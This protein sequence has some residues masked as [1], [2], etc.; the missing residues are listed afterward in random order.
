[1]FKILRVRGIS[2]AP[3][4]LHGD[5][6]LLLT[7]SW[8]GLLKPNRDVVFRHSEHG[9]LLKRIVSL[10]WEDQYCRVM[11][12]HRQSMNATA[13]GVIAFDD[14]IGMVIRHMPLQRQTRR[15]LV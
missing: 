10:D 14:L 15:S 5:F 1:M 13:L 4:Y 2:M 12:I 9:L 11:G 8:R 7:W 3:C 6:V